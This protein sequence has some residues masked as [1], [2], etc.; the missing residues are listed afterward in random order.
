MTRPLFFW[1]SSILAAVAFAAL[2]G[3]LFPYEAIGLETP[4]DRER[5][6]LLTTWTSG[7]M[8]I[9][10]GAAGLLSNLSPLGFRDVHDV[11]SVTAALEARREEIRRTRASGILY[12]FA[13]WTVCTGVWLVLVYF[14]GW[15]VM[16][17]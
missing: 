7:V 12:N 11:G 9:C 14:A 2:V 4:A 3:V 6:W 1:I 5:A 17:R 13:G 10:F 15:I 16:G 8:A